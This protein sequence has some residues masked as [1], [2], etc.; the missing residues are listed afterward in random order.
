[1]RRVTRTKLHP[2]EAADVG[3]PIVA[4][5]LIKWLV[6]GPRPQPDAILRRL[7]LHSQ[8]KTRTL[9]LATLST[10][11]LTVMAAVITGAAWAYAWVAIEV[12]FG[13]ARGIVARQM[14]KAQASDRPATALPLYLGLSWALSYSIGCALCVMSDEWPLFV[15]VAIVIA[16]LT[17]AIVSRNAGMPRYGFVQ[18]CILATP[19][20]VAMIFS[21]IP[22]MYLVGLLIPAWGLGMG[23][24]LFENYDVLLNLFLSERENKWLA[25][26]DQL[27]GLPNRTMQHRR[28]EELLRDATGTSGNG[29]QPLTV[30]WLDL[31]GFKA[32]ND[33]YGHELG[34]AVLVVVAER[35]RGCVRG[36]DL[37]FRVGGDEFVI[38]L[39]ATEAA[40]SVEIANRV[41]ARIAE[42]FDLGKDVPLSIGVSIGSA[43]FPRDGKTADDLLRSADSAMYEAKRLGKGVVVHCDSID[44]A[45]SLV[46][47]LEPD[48]H[49]TGELRTRSAV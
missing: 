10:T 6:N 30:L 42:P 13:I 27:T 23:I 31:D 48:A 41:I 1:M 34:D 19:Y 24:L 12:A 46:P 47:A 35:L 18:I 14:L 44:D 39:P 11:L 33:R 5:R 36:D 2:H 21:P 40:D 3:H 43:T 22:Q 45:P 25:N 9:F 49:I 29:C 26:Y 4:P 38:L 15:L 17:S 8:T 32:A 20:T 16:G 28:F 7:L 37:I